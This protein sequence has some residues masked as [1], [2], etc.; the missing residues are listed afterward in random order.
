MKQI[1]QNMK[2]GQTEIIEVPIPVLKPGFLLVRTAAS[3]VSAGTERMLVEFAEKSMVGKAR[4]RPDLVK[5][6]IQKAQRDG[7]LTTLESA[8]NRLD[9][10]IVLGYSS[11][12]TVVEV[13]EGVNQFKVGDRVACGGGGYAVH[14]EYA[15]IPKNLAAKLPDSISFEEGAFA[16]IGAIALNGIRIAQPQIGENTAVIGLGLL[17]LLSTQILAANGCNAVGMDLDPSRIEF[18]QK[19]GFAAFTNDQVLNSYLQLTDG[20]GFDHVFIC[21]DT[22]SNQP[23][24]IAGEIAR[25]R[26]TITA[27]GAVGMDIPRKP[28]YEKELIFKV[29][30]SYGP[31]RY[32]STYEEQGQDYPAG[33]VRWTEGR[34]IASVADLIGEQK[35]DVKSLI[36]H[37]F[38]ID[39]A[40]DAYHLLSGKKDEKYMGLIINYPADKTIIKN[41][42]LI[43]LPLSHSQS[44]QKL[45]KTG[46]IGAGNYAN[47]VCL[48]IIQKHPLSVPYLIASARG[49][50]AKQSAKKYNFQFATSDE[51]EI[52]N[53]KDIDIAV[54]LTRHDTHARLTCAALE[55]GKHVYCEKPLAI[56]KD[57]IANIIAQ[58]EKKNHP[59]L[60]VGFNRRFAPFIQEIK[61][62]LKDNREPIYANYRVNAG[63][64]PQDHWLHDL[65]SG[66]GRLIGEACHFI[67]LIL[68]LVGSTPT[69]VNT[70]VL[71][72][73]GKYCNDNFLIMFNFTDGSIATISYMAN[74]SKLA[75]K[76]YLELFSGG[77]SIFMDDYKKLQIFDHSKKIKRSFLRQ[78]KGHSAAWDAFVRSI[79]D[80]LP[81]PISN[82]DL[83]LSSYVTLAC[84]QSMQDGAPV[85][86]QDFISR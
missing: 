52:L 36:S 66:G 23:V 55:K 46:V 44:D 73:K 65:Q 53:N 21:A 79:I 86:I 48:P 42:R 60:T 62:A 18:A 2:D 25:D 68:F 5:Q 84:A 61:N 47:V 64:L 58:L 37:R 70:Q 13:G 34:N 1:V 4:S 72:N 9:Q 69:T 82:D 77:R 8:F 39:Q 16:T 75:G 11:A 14:A 28:Y 31:G 17:G 74:G 54:I 40:T 27:I 22:G 78:D 38:S 41:A 56:S 12:G 20:H 29:S 80:Q 45:L 24:E 7:I 85:I 32:D 59:Y 51:K 67:D 81:P 26:G 19:M 10:P 57:G 30:R 35:I 83:I 63:Y 6:V 15:L 43:E 50:H 76:E 33:Y 49:L 71:P 3:L